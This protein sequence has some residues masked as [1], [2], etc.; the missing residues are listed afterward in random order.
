MIRSPQT[1]TGELPAPIDLNGV[2]HRQA[3]LLGASLWASSAHNTQPW[4]IQPVEDGVFD[5]KKVE[6]DLDDPEDI[7]APLTMASLA[8]TMV[9][10][11]PNF[12]FVAS[13][14][15]ELRHDKTSPLVV[16]VALRDATADDVVDPL[17]AAVRKR[18]VNRNAYTDELM[19]QALV[20]RLHAL[21]NLVV[22]TEDV[23]PLVREASIA[24]LTSKEFVADLK[25]WFS[26]DLGAEAGVTPEPF[27][28]DRFSIPALRKL[29]LDRGQAPSF[30]ARILAKKEQKTFE[31]GPQAAVLSAEGMERDLVFEAGRRL[32]RSWVTV[33]GAGFSY[34]PYHGL[35][36]YPEIRKTLA[37]MTGVDNPVAAYRVG[38]AARPPK[39]FSNR[40][41]LRSRLIV[42]EGAQ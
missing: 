25:K 42:S 41:P 36:H 26:T 30:M 7:I 40:A 5:L 34:H 10:E 39:G 33:T 11:A 21:G 24:S 28:I 13:V 4:K 12:G 15:P 22:A 1:F 8:E 18:H 37:E 27:N 23:G 35:I 2:D 6:G 32:L 17:S 16:R 20:T 31:S 9:L 19:P 38:Y 14:D 29:V 3:Q